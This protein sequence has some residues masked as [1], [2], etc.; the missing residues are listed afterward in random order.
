MLAIC[1]FAQRNEA[2]QIVVVLITTHGI[3]LSSSRV[4]PGP[5]TFLVVNRTTAA[6]AEVEIVPAAG[7]SAAVSRV[8]TEP[9][10]RKVA[11][12]VPLA[13][14]VYTVRIKNV[15]SNKADIS[16]AP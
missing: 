12:E 13:S 7:E 9:N 14:G 6:A 1:C 5:V 15:P 11:K 16:V 4:K 10:G 2:K 3:Q 8:Q